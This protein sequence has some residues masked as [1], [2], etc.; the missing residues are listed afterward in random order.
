MERNRKAED[1]YAA[2]LRSGLSEEKIIKATRTQ[3]DAGRTDSVAWIVF[4]YA[5]SLMTQRIPAVGVLTPELSRHAKVAAGDLWG[6]PIIR[7]VLVEG[8]KE[9]AWTM[10]RFVYILHKK[11]VAKFRSN[12]PPMRVPP[13]ELPD[14]ELIARNAMLAML[15]R[16][17]LL[18]RRLPGDYD[19]IRLEASSLE[20]ICKEIS[21]LGYLVYF[22]PERAEHLLVHITDPKDAT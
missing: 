7:A 22:E 10:D 17:C 3:V 19:E 13:P 8:L 12:R 15:A 20:S 5:L 16:Q 11:W 6:H 4:E 14:E 18:N 2:L 21:R 1:A 9:S